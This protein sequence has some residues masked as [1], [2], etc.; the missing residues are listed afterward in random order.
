MNI[1]DKIRRMLGNE[2]YEQKMYQLLNTEHYT[3]GQYKQEDM[4]EGMTLVWQVIWSWWKPRFLLDHTTHCAYEIM[5]SNYELVTVTDEDIDWDSLKDLPENAV[6]R[7]KMHNAMYPTLIRR[8]ENGQAKVE[9]QINPDGKYWMDDDGFGMTRDH[10]LTLFG[11]IDRTGK[12]VEK[13]V[14]K[15]SHN[16]LLL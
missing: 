15:E 10:E 16:F 14:Y 13:F 11:S 9:W 8:F 4:G 5:N 2:A 1:Y 3:Q 6:F 7:A 12:V